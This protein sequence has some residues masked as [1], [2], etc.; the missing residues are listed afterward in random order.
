MP[1]D[2]LAFEPQIRLGCFLFSLLAFAAWEF[3]KP[4]RP[5]TIPL[6]LRWSANLGLVMISSFLSRAIIPLAPVAAATLAAQNNYGLL[7]LTLLPGWLEGLIAFVLLDLLIYAQHRL[8]HALPVLWRL[9]RTHHTD[10]ELDVSSG[11]RFH[12]AEFVL[13][14]IIKIMAVMALGAPPM[15]VLIFEI[16]LNAT[17]LFNHANAALPVRIDGLLRMVLVTPNMHRVHH[18]IV[19][20][21]TDSNFGFNL[22]WWDKLFGTYRAAP[23]AGPDAV[24]L[25][26]EN[27]RQ[28]GD[29]RLDRL[30]IQPLL[31]NK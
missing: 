16:V 21:E 18:S 5:R 11:V 1:A 27:F 4:W 13:S 26:I 9:H 25:G 28:A 15:A 12:P 14:L 7:T 2:I 31:A 22:P 23:A 30:L 20:A 3:L 6:A 29:S 19:K 10:L 24:T 8:F 17:S